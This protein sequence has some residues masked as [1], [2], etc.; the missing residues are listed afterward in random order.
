MSPR[1]SIIIATFNRSDLLPYSV[2]SVLRQTY[3]DYEVLVVGDGCTDDSEE[4]VAS[5]GDSRIRWINLAAN[6]GHQSAPNNE[7]I[8]Q[9]RGEIIAYLG[10][11]D[12]WLP[13]H[14]DAHVA[15]LDANGADLASSLCALV[16][17]DGAFW[18]AIPSARNKWFAPPTCITHRRGVVDD[19][20]G[21]KD[22]R[23][24]DEARDIAPDIELWRRAHA[25]GRKHAF[26]R[27]LTGIKFPGSM[28]RDVY[29]K[30]S[31]DEQRN[32]LDRV[33]REP[34][35]ETTLLVDLVD[36]AG[37]QQLNGVPYLE[38]V[39]LFTHQTARRIRRRFANRAS[40][41]GWARPARLEDIRR[42]KGL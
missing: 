27:R 12:L 2:G 31:H 41:F 15:A 3:A 5:I 40:A 30:R 16:E 23:T 9:A 38:L 25:A 33:D 22:Y 35:L 7:G 19:L 17:P 18:P 11:D 24:I 39:R 21:W 13:H 1:V 6:S 42:F 29:R 34:S 4:I 14:L 37:G 20:G 8:R 32:W 28:R 26:V 10:H 36:F